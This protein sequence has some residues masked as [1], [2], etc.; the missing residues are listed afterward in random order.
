MFS[1]ILFEQFYINKS[2]ANNHNSFLH[3]IELNTPDA[4][5]YQFYPFNNGIVQFRVRAAHDA[6][7][8]LSGEP[9]ETQPLI[10]IFI[11]GWKNTKSVIRYNKEKPEV[12]EVDTPG[13]LSPNEF[14]GFWIRATDGVCCH[15]NSLL[16]LDLLQT[17]FIFFNK[18]FLFFL[19]Y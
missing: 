19:I 8:I 1:S 3:F 2:V 18:N 14:R 12:D 13:I 15:F 10:E 4:L 5:E 7:L 6:H 16:K 9:H 11:G 17:C